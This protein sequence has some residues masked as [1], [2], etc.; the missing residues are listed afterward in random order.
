MEQFP[1]KRSPVRY[2]D[3]FDGA[4]GLWSELVAISS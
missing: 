2:L 1:P 3:D 4:A